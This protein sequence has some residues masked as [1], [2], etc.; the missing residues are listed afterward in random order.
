MTATINHTATLNSIETEKTVIGTILM[1][2]K[3]FPRFKGVLSGNDFFYS[4]HTRMFEVMSLLHEAGRDINVQTMRNVFKR[5]I[6]EAERFTDEFLMD[7]LDYALPVQNALSSATQISEMAGRRKLGKF[8]EDF[9][10]DLT[11]ME[12]GELVGKMQKVAIEVST[13]G[14]TGLVSHGS[15]LVANTLKMLAMDMSSKSFIGIPEVDNN[16]YDVSPGETIVIAAR[17]GTGK[18]TLMLQAVRHLAFKQ[19]KRPG[20]LS[21]EMYDGKLALRLVAGHCG[22]D[23]STLLTMND[24]DFE[25]NDLLYNGLIDISERV[26]IEHEG[27]FTAMTVQSKI[28][29]MVYNFGCDIIFVDYIGLI[30]GDKSTPG[31]RQQQVSD[32]SRMLKS[33]ATELYIPIVI[34][35]QLNRSVEHRVSNRPMLSD[36]RESGSIEQDASVVLFLYADIDVDEGMSDKD[37]Q[38]K[39]DDTEELPVIIECAKQRNGPVFRRR[40]IFSKPK[41]NFSL[42]EDFYSSGPNSDEDMPFAS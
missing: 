17:P 37:F 9:Q 32:I 39:I 18:T 15:L 35:A 1:T 8:L 13:K 30:K 21:M 42:A 25:A 40:L 24:E 7:Y 14:V 23:L 16:L 10:K 31:D 33:L 4:E 2:E 26:W 12:I 22:V 3:S 34:A 36:L 28:Q 5:N 6:S 38:K 20:F 41:M 19:H 27:S 11:N 29:N